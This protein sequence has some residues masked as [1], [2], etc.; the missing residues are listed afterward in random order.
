ML[1]SFK[2]FLLLEK[3]GDEIEVVVPDK[4]SSNSKPKKTEEDPEEDTKPEENNPDEQDEVEEKDEE[5]DDSKKILA[6]KLLKMFSNKLNLNL[7]FGDGV[8]NNQ[9]SIWSI[10]TST[11]DNFIMDDKIGKVLYDYL[12]DQKLKPQWLGCVDF[13][14]C[15]KAQQAKAL[16]D[17]IVVRV[18][19]DERTG[20]IYCYDSAEYSTPEDAIK[21]R[22][23]ILLFGGGFSYRLGKSINIDNLT[24]FSK[25]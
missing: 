2:A 5:E 13:L 22:G 17:Q 11:N 23:L 15:F 3:D 18:Q 10:K 14:G 16:V 6:S 21:G 4:N 19:N 1:L 9:S 24:K 12:N 8:D 20:G 7:K 25:K